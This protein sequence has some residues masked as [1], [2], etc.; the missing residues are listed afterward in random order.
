MYEVMLPLLPYLTKHK[1][2]YLALYHCLRDSILSG[3]LACGERLP[4]SRVLA[5]SCSFSRG[6]VNQV[7]E[8]LTADGYLETK[9]GSGTF[10]SYTQGKP[11]SPTHHYPRSYRLSDWADRIPDDA[12]EQ[13]GP[14][15]VSY[16]FSYS[17]PL[18]DAFPQEEWKKAVKQGLRDIHYLMDM[19]EPPKQGLYELR[20]AVSRYL[21][22]ARGIDVSPDEIVITN[23]SVHAMAILSHLLVNQGDEVLVENPSY[24]RLR[25]MIRTV[26]GIPVPLSINEKEEMDLCDKNARVA[27]V[28][29]TSQYP[30]GQIMP[31]NDR[32]ALLD[33]ARNTSSL[34]IEDDIDSEFNR[35]RK[36]IEPL[37][38]LDDE[39]RVIYLGTFAFS[40]L[41]HLRIGYAVLPKGILNDFIKAKM[42]FEPYTTS[43]FEQKAIAAFL[44]SGSFTKHIRRMKRIYS[45]KYTKLKNLLSLHLPDCFEWN[46]S[47]AGL[48]LFAWW[49]GT[50]TQYEQ[51]AAECRKKGVGWQNPA[52]YF[53]GEARPCA[54]FSFT[55]FSD[56]DMEKAVGIM[57]EVYLQLFSPVKN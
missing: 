13:P 26:G 10:V 50:I 45:Q 49:K 35:K 15:P 36:P 51:F 5:E 32:L 22:M 39:G 37:K 44:K 19:P 46:S 57:K 7:Y 17:R 30:T 52:E 3:R 54:L 34:I 55:H 4:S 23:G 21:M 18:Y 41:V 2:K 16:D 31:M 9:S 11:K 29:P 38:A 28:T 40:I 42:I 6:I 20:E 24:T 53:Y 8:M 25:N 27:Y 1:L 12:L 47:E 43:L 56:E 14:P 48:Y 33:W